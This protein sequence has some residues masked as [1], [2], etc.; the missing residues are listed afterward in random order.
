[1]K[2]TAN[3][4]DFF[5]RLMG[6]LHFYANRKLAVLPRIGSVE[7]LTRLPLAERIKIRDALWGNPALIEAYT[8]ENPDG[9]REEEIETVRKW[10]DFTAG[11]FWMLRQ[12]KQG[13][14][15]IG[16]GGLMY[17]VLAIRDS[18]E[19]VLRGRPLPVI[20]DTVLLPFQGRIVYDGFMSPHGIGVGGGMRRAMNEAYMSAKQNGR[21]IASLPPEP[22]DRADAQTA[23]RS[24]ELRGRIRTV[25]DSV[26][27]F[28]GHTPVQRSALQLLRAS[29]GLAESAAQSPE[30]LD[31]LWDGCANVTRALAGLERV[32][33]RAE[34]SCSSSG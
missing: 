16:A 4:A 9:L 5:F 15:F 31:A 32:L 33:E 34:A 25:V 19:E 13:A 28:K 29:A 8:R 26:G 20:V 17:S 3:E 30:D 1:M 6:R 2:V 18:F 24:A 7:E 14:I 12:L 23:E 27:G 22:Y 11:T 21:M 10:M